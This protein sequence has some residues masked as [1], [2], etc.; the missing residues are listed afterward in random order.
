MSVIGGGE[1]ANKTNSSIFR[2]SKLPVGF[3]VKSKEERATAIMR[4]IKHVDIVAE[5]LDILAYEVC[6]LNMISDGRWRGRGK[7]KTRTRYVSKRVV[8]KGKT[9]RTLEY[10]LLSGTRRHGSPV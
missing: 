4:V 8:Q 10:V 6:M 3:V 7:P 2:M 5:T 9:V 1:W